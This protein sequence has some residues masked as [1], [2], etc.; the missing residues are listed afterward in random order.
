[1]SYRDILMFIRSLLQTGSTLG[2]HT[3]HFCDTTPTVIVL[4]NLSLGYDLANNTA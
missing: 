1:M 3:P 4:P 2:H